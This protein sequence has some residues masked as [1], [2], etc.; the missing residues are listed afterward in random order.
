MLRELCV[1][2]AEKALVL[3][4]ADCVFDSGARS[5]TRAGRAVAL[6]PK[7]FEL[8]LALLEARPRALS[9][10]E[11]HDRLWPGT[12]VSHYSLPRVVAEA[13]RA[14]GDRRHP[15]R[16]L[17]TVHGF[18]YSFC[19]EAQ[20]PAGPAALPPA[21][22]SRFGLVWQSR[23]LPLVPGETLIGR[24][25]EC[26]IRIDRPL[27]SRR[28]ARIRIAGGVA[29]LEDLGSKNGTSMGG[30]RVSRPTG[31]ADGAEIVVGS[32][33]LVFRDSGALRSTRTGPGRVRSG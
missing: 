27:I 32:E 18:G 2:S 31:L 22:G 26:A 14:L 30:K 33:V 20:A 25:P 5:L 13:R 3:V 4:F 23:T 28:H 16:F 1:V 12:F 15:A 6:S 17:R 29:T 10:A 8:L 11:L 7:A 9:R 19:G 24:D 21:T